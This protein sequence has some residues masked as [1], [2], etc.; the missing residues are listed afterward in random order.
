MRAIPSVPGFPEVS[1]VLATDRA[2]A[3]LD[4][5]VESCLSYDMLVGRVSGPG[6]A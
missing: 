1:G 4:G 6:G 2:E 5:G 3:L